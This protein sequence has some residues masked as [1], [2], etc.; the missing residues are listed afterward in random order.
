V[1]AP[2]EASTPRAVGLAASVLGASAEPGDDE[3]IPF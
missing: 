2:A 3:D 1:G